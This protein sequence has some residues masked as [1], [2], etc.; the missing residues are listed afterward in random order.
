M[1]GHIQCVLTQT[2]D[3]Y[4]YAAFE[5]SFPAFHKLSGAPVY[6][7]HR[8]ARVIGVITDST[9]HGSQQGEEHT[10]A[11]WSLAA[12]L[13]RMVD[14]LSEVAGPWRDGPAARG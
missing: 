1:Q 10:Y 5:L 14:W 12:S 3:H 6:I 7:P 9:S 11:A 4:R 2:K 13:T 8:P